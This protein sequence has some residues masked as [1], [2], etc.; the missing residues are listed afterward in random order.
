MSATTTSAFRARIVIKPGVGVTSLEVHPLDNNLAALVG[1]SATP[2]P[3]TAR[4]LRTFPLGEFERAIKESA[5]RYA[6]RPEAVKVYADF[7]RS[8]ITVDRPGRRGR[9]PVEYARIAQRYESFLGSPSPIAALAEAEGWEVSKARNLVYEARRRGFL[10]PTQ[11]GQADG[12][13]TAK[14]R[15]LLEED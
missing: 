6:G 3:L 13:L 8:A 15:Q 11:P 1:E 14:A 10:T 9:D 5:R 7:A 12:Q 2:M 4:M